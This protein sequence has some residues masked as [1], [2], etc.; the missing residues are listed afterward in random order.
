MLLVTILY[1]ITTPESAELG[2]VDESGIYCE[3]KATTFRDLVV[4]LKGGQPSSHP[5][6]GSPNEWVSQDQGET[7]AFFSYGAREE[8]TIH[9]SDANPARKAKYWALAFRA[10]GLTKGE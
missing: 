9:L 5:A 10:A 4:M 6:T 8:R 7:Y 1:T 2:E 3:D